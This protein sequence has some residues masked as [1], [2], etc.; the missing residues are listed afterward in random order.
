LK[1]QPSELIENKAK[2]HRDKAIDEMKLVFKEV[3]YG[4]EHTLRVLHNADEIMS[5]ENIAGDVA[6]IVSLSAILHDVGTIEAQRK[7]GSMEGHFQEIEGPAI[8]KE[9]LERIGTP[10]EINERVC[11]IVGNHHTLSRIDGLDF[12]IL[13]EADFLDNL[14]FGEQSKTREELCS[15]IRENFKTATGRSL[16]LKRCGP[17]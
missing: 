17:L 9:I 16:A 3:P 14:E 4:I 12:Q 15:A 13:W 10:D 11:Y 5:G 2:M 7:H 8:A 6:E 1:I